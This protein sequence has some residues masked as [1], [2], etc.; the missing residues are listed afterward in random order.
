MIES[1]WK[2]YW[3]DMIIGI[4]AITAIVFMFEKGC[5][6]RRSCIRLK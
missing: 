5:R 2:K 1:F 3:F 6:L 4:C